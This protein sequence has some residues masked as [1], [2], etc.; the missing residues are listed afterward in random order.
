MIPRLLVVF[1]W[2]LEILGTA[3][4]VGWLRTF[5]SNQCG[6]GSSHGINTPCGLSFLLVLVLSLRSFFPWY[7]G[8]SPP[9]QLTVPNSF[10]CSYITH[11][12]LLKC[13]L[14]IIFFFDIAIIFCFYIRNTYFKTSSAWKSR[15]RSSPAL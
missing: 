8:F 15:F 10:M 11:Q 12:I 7:F 14:M 13:E 3:L 2:Q 4:G 9:Q 6:I 1:T 5:A